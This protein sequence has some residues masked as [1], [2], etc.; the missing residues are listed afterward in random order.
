MKNVLIV[1]FSNFLFI[2]CNEAYSQVIDRYFELRGVY[3]LSKAAHPT[4]DF[5]S[6]T[7]DYDIKSQSIYIVIR[8]RDSFLGGV[9]E[10]K[11]QI[12]QGFGGLYFTN[13]I[14]ISDTDPYP[15]FKYLES[16]MQTTVGILKSLNEDQY[17][18]MRKGIMQSFGSDVNYWTGTTWGL[19][20]LNMDYFDNRK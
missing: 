10:T 11:L 13:I 6:G 14:V 2:S 12:T 1:I 3:Q 16:A 5:I 18:L 15:P 9:S 17:N 20:M 4:N 19:I 8:S 7:F